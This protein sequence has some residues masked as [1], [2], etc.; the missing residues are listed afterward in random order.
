MHTLGPVLCALT[1]MLATLAC[2]QDAPAKPRNA[3]YRNSLL[4]IH[5]DNHSGALGQGQSVDDLTAAFGT[6]ACD[7]IQVSA[8]SNGYATYP[9]EVGLRNPDPYDTVGTFK[10][11]T[12]RLGR[13]LCVYMSVDRRPM[14]FKL[15]PEW[16]QIGADGKPVLN[17]EPVVCQR[18]N[19]DHKGYLYE[20]FL[21][22]IREIIAK[23]DPEG[24][25]FDGDYIL[26]RPCWCPRC[27]AAWR[28]ETG[29][30]APRDQNSPDWGKWTAW[31]YSRYQEY[32]RIV[33]EAI[34]EASP[35]AL[36]T[37][38][39]SW[40]WSPEPAPDFVDTLSGD[41]WNL[42]QVLLT[43]ARWGAQQKVPW[44]IMSY[45]V[46]DGRSLRH[47]YSF[48]RTLQEGALT[49]A[50]GGVWF[51]W[52]FSAGQ[53]PP[54]GIETTRWMADFLQDRKAALGPSASLSSVAVL[55]AEA[56]WQRGGETGYDGP[57]CSAAR[58]LIEARYTADIVNEETLRQHLTPYQVVVVPGA[59]YVSAETLADLRSFVESGG[60]VLVT[61]MGLRG[62]S[63]EEDPQVAAFL[64]LAR[65]EPADT[66]PAALDLGTRQYVVGVPGV[67][68]A[69]AEVLAGL[70]DGRPALTKHSVGKGIVGY[71]AAGRI[72]YPDEGL[73]AAAL[74]KLGKGPS[75]A[76]DGVGD[77]PVICRLRRKPGQIVAHLVDLGTRAQGQTLDVD[78]PDYTDPNP[79][80][81]NVRLTLPLASAPKAVSV[82]PALSTVRT[83]YA[84]GRLEL[85]VGMLPTHAAVILQTDTAEAP[86]MLPGDAPQQAIAW[87]PE[88]ERGGVL[89]SEDFEGLPVGKAPGKP[90]SSEVK[91]ATAIAVTDQTAA[92]GTRCLKLTDAPDSSFWPYFHRS[93]AA[94]RK[95]RSVLSFDLRVDPGAKCLIEVRYEGK[96]PGPCVRFDG[97]GTLW[98][99][100]RG[101]LTKLQ[102]GTWCHVT[103]EYVLGTDKP[104]YSLTVKPAGGEAQT[105]ADLPYATE[106][107]FLCNSVYFV[108]TAESAGDFYLDNLR[109]ERLG[110]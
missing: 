61:G 81:R 18:P 8:Q 108:G 37:S 54:Q 28:T 11:V 71:L 5:C 59:R 103:I 52:T 21:P 89:F 73:L 65:T 43:T 62:D 38:N 30:D 39:W 99:S 35:K 95:G 58:S 44:D 101:D 33:A 7:M 69:G 36:Y 91:G 40:A 46:P 68:V 1:L 19:A 9:T 25:W 106:W 96:G 60:V 70:A 47:D 53:V 110:E 104:G 64:G 29:T 42:K 66:R 88:A 16:F 48:Q 26:T 12:R 92:S 85:T 72:L 55:D 3:W 49:I 22:Q 94:Y 6:I 87:H 10:E 74:R 82:V 79:V 105:W 107:F 98:A 45:Q 109:L 15:H 90:W 41:A 77:A 20:R 78:A 86:G 13:K 31:H 97:D 27:L 63:A 17:G 50:S 93:V 34:H 57:A 32:R 14:D 2:G 23:Y 56:S 84:D 100:G 51:A 75:Y 83:N 76:V 80:L 4:S 102:P 67:R 24:F